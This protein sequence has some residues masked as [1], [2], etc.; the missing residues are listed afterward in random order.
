[1]DNTTLMGLIALAVVILAII[2]FSTR[3]RN[4][5]FY[6]VFLI[7]AAANAWFWYE[8]G[9]ALGV[10][11]AVGAAALG[12]SA[13]VLKVQHQGQ[14]GFNR[15]AMVWVLR[16]VSIYA[17]Y[18]AAHMALE[19]HTGG[20]INN[21]AHVATL[22]RDIKAIEIELESIG[23]VQPV[24]IIK[25]VSSAEIDRILSKRVYDANGKAAG[26]LRG[27]SCT[28]GYF[29]KRYASD[30]ER[31]LSA[32]NKAESA[33]HLSEKYADLVNRRK[34]LESEVKNANGGSVA[35]LPVV[36]DI[37]ELWF[38]VSFDTA[39]SE[40][41]QQLASGSAQVFAII[42]ALVFELTLILAGLENSRKGGQ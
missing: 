4:P 36:R 27:V 32:Q 35:A 10:G 23:N 21:S 24:E 5:V 19:Q 29:A 16:L 6:V 40:Q 41:K 28:S 8:A 14:R 12:L 7:S 22:Q 11:F 3:N 13:D 31:Y 37:S 2:G 30:C 38:G 33:V 26:T 25:G 42:M 34:K 1:M 20:A 17:G 39:T 9:S 18:S 15:A